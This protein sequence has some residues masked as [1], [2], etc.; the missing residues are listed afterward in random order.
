MVLHQRQL[1]N[2]ME[3]LDSIIFYTIDKAIRSYRQYAQKQL[4]LRGIDI[5]VDQWLVLKALLENP[6]A[7]QNE[8]SEQVFKDAASVN[9]IITLLVKN[10]YMERKVDAKNRRLTILK[11]SSKGHKILSDMDTIIQKNREVALEGVN[12]GMKDQVMQAMRLI[13]TN[14]QK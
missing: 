6:K 2:K 8:L 9:R 3:K 10:G 5:T 13:T 11:V 4:K 1:R 14:T 7:Q 12:E